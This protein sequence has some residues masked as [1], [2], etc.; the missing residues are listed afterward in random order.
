MGCI[1]SLIS[2]GD[3]RVSNHA[4]NPDSKEW[5]RKFRNMLKRKHNRDIGFETV[6]HLFSSNPQA[7]SELY[8]MWERKETDL[9]FYIPQVGNF[10]LNGSVENRYEDI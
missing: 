2:S 1:C 7:I 4:Y 9:I 5:R 6:L 8:Q 3:A 10:L